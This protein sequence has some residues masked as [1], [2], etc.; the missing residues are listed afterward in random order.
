MVN[1]QLEYAV[2]HF[3]WQPLPEITKMAAVALPL[4]TCN[5][6]CNEFLGQSL[7]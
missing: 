5:E 6:T 2:N 7:T 4:D 1:L 3:G